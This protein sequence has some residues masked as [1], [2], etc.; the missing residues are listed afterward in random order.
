MEIPGGHNSKPSNG[1]DFFNHGIIPAVYQ[2]GSLGASG[3]LAPLGIFR[4]SLGMGEVYL[5]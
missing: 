3:D 4:Y 1:V 5:K 2:L